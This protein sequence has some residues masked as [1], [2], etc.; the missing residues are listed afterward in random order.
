MNLTQTAQLLTLAA[1][2]DQRT[3]GEVDV[4]AWADLLG[5]VEYADAQQ[6]VKTHYATETRRVMPVDVIRGARR[7][8]DERGAHVDPFAVPAADPDDVPGYLAALRSG[9]QRPRGVL[10]DRPI[11]AALSRTQRPE[12]A[13]S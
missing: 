5:G 7:I 2:Y 10:H 9:E 1:A 11:R 13:A 6:A 4:R 3:I 12:E 8:A